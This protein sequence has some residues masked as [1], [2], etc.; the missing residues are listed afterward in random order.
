[1]T[2]T[3]AAS[4]AQAGFGVILGGG[5]VAGLAWEIGL[6]AGLDDAGVD[7]TIADKVIGTS[8]GSFA[9][10]VWLQ[11]GGLGA[12]F[13]GQVSA[14]VAEVS[15]SVDPELQQAYGDI[16]EESGTDAALAGRLFGELAR[17]ATTITP[18][19]RLQVVRARLGTEFWP[20]RL[21]M[22]AI[23]AETGQLHILT[24]GSGLSL[25]EAAA[26]SG[27]VAGVWPVV[28]A[29]GH[30]WIDGGMVSAAN[31]GLAS[32]FRSAIVIAPI[33]RYRSGA[34]VWDEVAAL[35]ST[36]RCFVVVPDEASVDAIGANP[37]DP[38]RRAI[39]AQAGRVQ[40]RALA[41]SAALASLLAAA[42]ISS[43]PCR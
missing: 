38:S 15:A 14:T 2:G 10:A 13:T 28:E 19:S 41:R 23:D 1:M 16:L 18:G 5:G 26:A 20:Q 21:A 17:T 32:A 40:G 34:T 25:L 33:A 31:A 24:S 43:T 7:L 22:T 4:D 30:T 27:A 8:A 6:L 12:A 39:A 29:G 42:E 37:L 11:E 9:G 35:P 36:T 3:H